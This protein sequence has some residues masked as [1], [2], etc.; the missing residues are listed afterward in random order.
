MVFLAGKNFHLGSLKVNGFSL[1]SRASWL[2]ISSWKVIF[3]IGW[4]VRP[5]ENIPKL[6]L[7]HLH[8]DHSLA[9]PTWL[10]W[11]QKFL[12][13]AS[14]VYLPEES[15]EDT[16]QW[17]E[18]LA[19]AEKTKWQYN[20]VGLKD[21]DQVDIGGGRV[22][23]AFSTTH[24]IPTLGFLVKTQR[25][26]LK[27]QYVGLDSKEIKKIVA[28]GKEVSEKREVYSLCYTSDTT[29]DIFD[30]RPDILS[31]EILITECSCLDGYLEYGTQIPVDE[32]SLPDYTHNYIHT[33]APKLEKFTGKVIA[34]NHTPH[35]YGQCDA[36]AYTLP[37]IP[38]QQRHKL[39][40]IPYRDKPRIHEAYTP[41]EPPSIQEYSL[42]ENFYPADNWEI[43]ER[44]GYAGW[45]K[46]KMRLE[47]EK[48]YP[49][50]QIAHRWDSEMLTR[51]GALQKYEDAYYQFL[52]KNPELLEWLVS[53]AAEVYDFEIENIQSGLDYHAQ[54][55]GKATH[56]QDIAI[57]RSL[58]RLGTWFR[59]NQ[60][61]QVRGLNSRGYVLNP[62]RVPFHEPEKIC[63][64]EWEADWCLKGSIE[65][66]WQSNKVVITPKID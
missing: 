51:D 66:F 56:L 40:Y 27:D 9:L 22:V 45:K 59:G 50:F 29:A 54:E 38:P 10:T 3:D 34:I 47:L 12:P 17:V 37:R 63:Q 57:R 53:T 49:S 32:K 28:E 1:A 44:K 24:Y 58:I 13:E 11:R 46:D 64:P 55:K 48:K 6:F 16:R 41:K 7:S 36:Y 26:K 18:A 20:L 43:K 31:S 65:S 5:M 8:Q 39:Q 60:L 15:L 61:I 4:C 14:T 35:R 23:E 30:Q 62:G 33:L 21:G 2:A 25:K 42:G 19:R 52:K